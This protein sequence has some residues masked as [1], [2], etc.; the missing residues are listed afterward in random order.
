MKGIHTL[1]FYLLLTLV[2]S[3][4]NL[5][6][7]EN[8]SASKTNLLISPKCWVIRHSP[9]TLVT[10]V[11]AMPQLNVD[12]VVAAAETVVVAAAAVVVVVVAAVAA[13]AVVVQT[14]SLDFYASPLDSSP[15]QHVCWD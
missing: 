8:V 13:V 6:K 14:P 12:A 5:I 1:R 4:K 7:L 3:C 11:P 10:L 15:R 9:E 2:K